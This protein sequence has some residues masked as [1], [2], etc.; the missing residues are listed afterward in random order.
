MPFKGI[1]ANNLTL[2]TRNE[3]LYTSLVRAGDVEA[4]RDR[5]S[6]NIS[7]RVRCRRAFTKA[8]YHGSR[9]KGEGG[10]SEMSSGE[11]GEGGYPESSSRDGPLK[12]SMLDR[13]V[14]KRK[15]VPRTRLCFIH[16]TR[17]ARATRIAKV[18][19]VR[20]SLAPSSTDGQQARA[21][22]QMFSDT[23]RN[24]GE[25]RRDGIPARDPPGWF[26]RP[27]RAPT[28]RGIHRASPIKRSLSLYS[29]FIARRSIY[30]L[31]NF[32]RFSVSY[33]LTFFTHRN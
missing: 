16:S 13:Q 22:E 17:E 1:P 33:F 12:G 14:R 7:A 4:A 26:R 32:A 19:D 21:I 18:Y 9:G 25:G 2:C 24:A 5:A 10:E 31:A 8:W 30:L 23:P 3:S 28:Y 11:G 6:A 29:V 20:S 27:S 15:F